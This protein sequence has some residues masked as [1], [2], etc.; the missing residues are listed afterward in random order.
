VAHDKHFEHT[1]CVKLMLS[2]FLNFLVFTVRLCCLSPKR[3]LS[4]RLLGMDI[5]KV[6]W[7]T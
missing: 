6:R 2:K 1:L 7:K 4:K 5:M 3:K